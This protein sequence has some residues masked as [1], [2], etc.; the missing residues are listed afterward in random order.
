MPPKKRRAKKPV[1]QKQKQSQ[2]VAQRVTVNIVQPKSKPR[3]RAIAN[4][5]YKAYQQAPQTIFLNNPPPNPPPSFPMQQSG[6]FT[7]Y[8]QRAPLGAEIMQE[9]SLFKQPEPVPTPTPV[10]VKSD[11]NPLQNSSIF[12]PETPIISRKTPPVT[13][14][15]PVITRDPFGI[16]SNDESDG[17]QSGAIFSDQATIGDVN[18]IPS[19]EPSPAQDVAQVGRRIPPTTNYNRMLK[20][21]LIA[22]AKKYDLPVSRL[23][24]KGKSVALT[25]DALKDSIRQYLDNNRMS[26]F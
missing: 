16:F 7:P 12:G 1:V 26:L 8:Q 25:N 23:N 19:P 21:Q 3:R 9:P 6:G 10:P 4:S 20:P 14:P 2:N 17:N 13:R 24:A 5:G 11:L 15:R 22:L 18:V